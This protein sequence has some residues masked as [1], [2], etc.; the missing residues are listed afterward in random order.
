MKKKCIIRLAAVVLL[1]AI[2]Q[3][4]SAQFVSFAPAKKMLEVD[5]HVFA[6]TT[7]IIQNYGNTFSSLTEV[8]ADNGAGIGGGFG[9][10]FGIREWVGFGTEL[11]ILF[12]NNKLN[13]AVSNAEAVSMSNIFVRNRYSYINIPLF[14]SFRFN[15]LP[16][17]RWNV[18]AGIYY[19]YG[20]GGRQHQTIYRS[21]VNDLGQLVPVTV[22]TKTG[23][24]RN[25]DTFLNSYY[26]GDIG[27][28]LAT[29]LQFGKHFF[30]GMRFQ[31]GMKNI[32]Y[33]HGIVNPD[34]H[35]L[36]FTG[37]LGYKL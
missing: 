22:E 34:I 15:I 7:G 14:M 20:L 31:V 32:S 30:V 25:D 36:N 26:R 8:T 1:A 9:A 16:G 28:H 6:G 5:A 17:L 24:F 18:D 2:P 21:Y 12:A 29:A 4:A 19:S 3:L 23:Y 13:M 37:C 11:N 27:L 33:N 35:N 10:V